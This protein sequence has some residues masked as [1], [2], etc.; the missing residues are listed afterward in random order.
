MISNVGT[1]EYLFDSL[2]KGDVAKT[3]GATDL[4]SECVII[5]IFLTKI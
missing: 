3:A 2:D 1:N 5:I 4:I